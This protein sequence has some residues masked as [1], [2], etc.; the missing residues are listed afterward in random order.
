MRTVLFAL[1]GAVIVSTA[2][3]ATEEP[4]FTLVVRDGAIEIR[5][6]APHIVAEV[7][8]DGDRR[9]ASSRGF[10][11]LANYIFGGNQPRAEI[12]MTAPVTSQQSGT[13][14]AMTAPVTR[15]PD[16]DGDWTVAFIMPSDWSMQTL[17]VPDD[18]SVRLREQP[19]RR[20]ASIQFSGQMSAPRAEAHLVELLTYL[21][22]QGATPVSAPTF[23][24]Y[25]PPWIP[26]PFR[27]NEI[28]LELATD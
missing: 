1:M 26:G 13:Q 17:P 16:Q 9:G 8:V 24:A 21:D 14:I 5:D 25:D 18:P 15:Q 28:W 6:Y 11:P 4:Q 2:A 10:R 12:A 3:M 27:R 23:A 20:I 7:T 22:A 19:A